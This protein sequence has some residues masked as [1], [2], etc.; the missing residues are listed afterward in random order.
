MTLEYYTQN[1][2]SLYARYSGVTTSDVH[3]SWLAS[4]QD[5][6]GLAC[7]IGAGS[8][9]DANW[10]ANNGW[11][12]V[13]VEPN[14]ALRDMA[15]NSAA[16]TVQFLD[17]SMPGLNNLRSKGHRFDLILLSAVWMHVP[18]T[19]RERA[20]RILTDMLAPGGLLVITL[21][22]S[23]IDEPERQFHPVSADEL[24][25]FANRR[26]I[27]LLQ[28]TH[29]QD[30]LNRAG[31]SWDTLVYKMPDDG[32]GGLPLLRHIIVNDNKSSTY[33]LGLLRAL[34]RI[35]EG[36]PGMVTRRTDTHVEIPLGLVGLYWLK[37]YLPLILQHNIL[38]MPAKKDGT[39]PGSGFAKAG[40]NGLGELTNYG[41]RVGAIY[42]GEMAG[43][44]AG[45]LRDACQSIQRMPAHFITF[46]GESKQ[47]FE[48]E[49]R[50]PTR[51]KGNVQLNKAYLESFGSFRIP[52]HVWQTLGQYACWLEPAIV[53]EWK[54]LMQGWGI[55]Y[56]DGIY[57]RAMQWEAGVRDTS[58]V[59][60]RV[61]ALQE[62]G[63][64]V[65]CA[66]TNA[67][68]RQSNFDIDHCFPWSYWSN[69][70]LWNLLPSTKSANG[71]KSNALPSGLLIHEARPRIMRWWETAYLDTALESQFFLEA[72]AALPGCNV[73]DASLDAVFDAVQHQRLR[74]RKDQQLREWD[75]P[76]S[77]R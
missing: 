34:V 16:P 75:G 1:A 30:A 61:E 77:A 38:Q 6:P 26:A 46:P 40:F 63:Q 55:R 12:V 65:H 2:Q 41:L 21:R 42:S 4:L 23:M 25:Q 49:Y 52:L 71:S 20:F 27:A 64:V 36:A 47:V 51:I 28:H 29:E 33:K 59:R 32:T 45:A 14:R 3:R 57:D 17:D 5:K 67:K 72:E 10:L 53:N 68:L 9:R 58:K 24:N 43:H 18:P 39:T 76:T 50:S 60:K 11:D 66:W 37:L 74:L 8:G 70:D 48:S 69:N 15:I 73:A 62:A 19:D 56:D 54:I 44:V 31:V 13:A 7:D 22:H 35:A